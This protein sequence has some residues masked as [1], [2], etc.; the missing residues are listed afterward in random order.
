[1]KNDLMKKVGEL[2]DLAGLDQEVIKSVTE[3]LADEDVVLE[4]EEEM[5]EEER[6]EE[7][8]CPIKH[9]EPEAEA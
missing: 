5:Q 8:A 6:V 7:A 3:K 4:G 1:M 2:L 9:E